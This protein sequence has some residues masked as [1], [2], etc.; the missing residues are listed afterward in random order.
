MTVAADRGWQSTGLKLE[1]GKSYLIEAEGRF[2]VRQRPEDW[3]CEPGGITLE[4]IHGRPLG[5]LIGNIRLDVPQPGVANLGTPLA[6]GQKR[7]IVAAGDGTLYLRV[8]DRADGL[9]DNVGQITVRVS[10]SRESGENSASLSGG[11][12]LP[13]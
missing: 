9:A 6:V 11:N 7:R 2:K 5:L 13:D 8:N 10:E 12:G 4:Y 3:W 1:A